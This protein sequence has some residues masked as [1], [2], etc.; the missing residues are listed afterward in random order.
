MNLARRVKL[1]ELAGQARR[2][3]CLAE[4]LTDDELAWIVSGGT[5]TAAELTDEELAAILAQG[6]QDEY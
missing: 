3:P 6:V 4:E 1:L 5:K 2:L